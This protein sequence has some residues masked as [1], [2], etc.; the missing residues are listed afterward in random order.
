MR[1]VLLMAGV[2]NLAWGLFIYNFPEAFHKWLTAGA[3]VYAGKLVIYQGIG[4]FVFG[5]MYILAT[6]YPLRFWYLI[7]LGLISKLVGAIG[8]YFLIINKTVT[9]QFIFH[10]LVND[11]AWVV[12]LAFITYRTF[13]FRKQQIYE[14]A[15]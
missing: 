13:W 3:V 9:K 5:I 4:V 10:V 14:K 2:Y 8:V 6:L 1:G 7:L 12:P 15:A 11:L